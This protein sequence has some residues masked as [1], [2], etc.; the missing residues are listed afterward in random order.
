MMKLKDILSI[1]GHS[2]LFQYISQG[3]NGIIVEGLEDKK[4][5]NAYSH[6]KVSTLSDIAIFAESGEINLKVILKKIAEK[7][8][9]GQAISAKSP[10]K[11]LKS[12]FEEILP[13]Y[14][15]ERVY[16]SD[17][18]KVISWYNLLQKLNLLEILNEP[19]EVVE[20]EEKKDDLKEEKIEKE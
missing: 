2:G 18:K 19:D 7:Q 14:D 8:E 6:Y 20:D 4:R 12:Y 15:R 1:S 10:D 9:N 16:T 17:I 11:E 5:L 3:R 13:D